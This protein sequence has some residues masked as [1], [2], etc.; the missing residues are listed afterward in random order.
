MSKNMNMSK[1]RLKKLVTTSVIC[2]ELDRMDEE[3]KHEKKAKKRWTQDWL[4]ARDASD[5]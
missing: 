1:K 5:G 4:K 3:E 2:E